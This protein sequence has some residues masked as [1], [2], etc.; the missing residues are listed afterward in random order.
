MRARK[1]CCT[2][3]RTQVFHETSLGRTRWKH[4]LYPHL[5]QQR[6]HF[7]LAG[8]HSELDS[9]SNQPVR[10]RS[11]HATAANHHLAQ[12]NPDGRG[13]GCGACRDV[14]LKRSDGRRHD[15][16]AAW[17]RRVL[18]ALA[19]RCA[20]VHPASDVCGDLFDRLL[21]RVATQLTTCRRLDDGARLPR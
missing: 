8:I 13:R 11:A 14:V 2:C 18:G 6:R 12:G 5:R 9:D 20:F 21:V 17:R 19:G 4:A 16:A 3:F 7:V 10:R 15:H 1:P